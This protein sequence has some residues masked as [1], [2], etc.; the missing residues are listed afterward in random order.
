ML[1]VGC[2]PQAPPRTSSGV[3]VN[4][5]APAHGQ[6]PRLWDL[7]QSLFPFLHFTMA[8]NTGVTVGGGGSAPRSLQCPA[9]SPSLPSCPAWNLIAPH[10]VQAAIPPA[11]KGKP[12]EGCGRR[13]R[14]D[15]AHDRPVPGR[16]P[17]SW[18]VSFL[19][20]KMSWQGLPHI[21]LQFR[22]VRW[23]GNGWECHGAGQGG[24]ASARRRGQWRWQ[25]GLWSGTQRSPE[26]RVMWVKVLISQSLSFL[27]SKMGQIMVHSL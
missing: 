26:H 14:M 25:N 20:S 2:N 21:G 12:E 8:P 5:T 18:R 6:S 23:L 11:P 3:L 15:E 1:R 7:G 10:R 24:S 9:G 19:G 27:T 17:I 16:L 13:C 22:S 4:S